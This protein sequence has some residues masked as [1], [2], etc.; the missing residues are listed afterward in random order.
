MDWATGIPPE[1]MIRITDVFRARWDGESFGNFALVGKHWNAACERVRRESLRM[2]DASRTGV[3]SAA[4]MYAGV[5]HLEYRGD[6]GGHYFPVFRAIASR[7]PDL[8]TLR[9]SG[10]MYL[11]AESLEAVSLRSDRLYY[12]SIDVRDFSPV[13]IKMLGMLPSLARADVASRRTGRRLTVG[14]RLS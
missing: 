3:M 12:V 2:T 11:D 14:G 10:E 8:E 1:V 5:K 7:F 13:C 6:T 4:R 9:V